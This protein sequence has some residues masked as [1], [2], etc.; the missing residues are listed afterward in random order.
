M[1]PSRLSFA[2]SE[3]A[4]WYLLVDVGRSLG[5][6]IPGVNGLLYLTPALQAPSGG[7]FDAS[8]LHHVVFPLPNANHLAGFQVHFQV[9][10]WAPPA[11]PAFSNYVETLTLAP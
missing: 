4:L 2:G 11:A 1:G 7:R 5:L 9:L 3:G 8:G 10:R 6:T